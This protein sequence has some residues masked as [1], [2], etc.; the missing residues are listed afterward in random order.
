MRKSGGLIT[1]STQVA[2]IDELK[3]RVVTGRFLV[4]PVA[5][6]IGGG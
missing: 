1:L 3:I 6:G 5:I 2:L 4:K